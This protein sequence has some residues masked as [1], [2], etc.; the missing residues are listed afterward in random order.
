MEHSISTRHDVLENQKKELHLDENWP[1]LYEGKSSS[2][3]PTHD[4]KE[5]TVP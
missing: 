4:K 2:E 3:S 5:P 1:I